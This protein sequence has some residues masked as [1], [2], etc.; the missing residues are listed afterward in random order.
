MTD[1]SSNKVN[2]KL[3]DIIVIDAPNDDLINNK[4]FLVDYVGS[5]QITLINLTDE[6]ADDTILYVED[7]NLRNES[8]ETIIIQKRNNISG[9]A[10]QNDLLPNTWI[11]IQFDG[12]IPLIIT[13]KISNLEED[14]IEI[15]TV[16]N[17]TIYIDF[18]YQGLPID[19][20]I[21]E[22]NIRGAPENID[23]DTSEDLKNM[24]DADIVD[25]M[26]SVDELDNGV[27][28]IY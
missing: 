18:A 6:K 12:N 20:N 13:G 15:K 14:Q 28:K 24:N 11:D 27:K 3:G 23:N 16:Q 4:L 9:Y 26:D 8:I 2:I 25:D 21:K 10:R 5:T 22:I 7:G 17:D 1:T 19:L